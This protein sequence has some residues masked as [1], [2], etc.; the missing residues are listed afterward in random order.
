[1]EKIILEKT[2]KDHLDNNFDQFSKYLD[3]KFQVFIELKRSVEEVAICLM[4]EFDKAA[5]TLTNNILVRLLKLSLIYNEVGIK[6]VP[7]EKWNL[8]FL[9][10]NR[11]YGSL[12]LG[13]TIEFCRE[14]NLITQEEKDYLVDS[15][16]KLISNGFSNANPAKMMEILVGEVV[17]VQENFSESSG[18]NKDEL[19]QKIIPPLQSI[20]IENFTKAN[21]LRYF[22]FIFE[23]IGNIEQ[24][25]I[26]KD[27]GI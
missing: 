16:K 10:P 5:I 4:F 17:E 12:P 7:I 19:Q 18:F 20:Q 11:K 23:L 25:L 26:K 9:E 1:M 13:K 15:V 3:N 27:T 14:Q 2:I 24:R 22:E 6:P 21:A 8:I